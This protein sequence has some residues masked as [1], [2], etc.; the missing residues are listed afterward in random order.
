MVYRLGYRAGDDP[1]NE[2]FFSFVMSTLTFP[3]NCDSLKKI[4]NDLCVE[5]YVYTNAFS[6]S[7]LVADLFWIYKIWN[8]II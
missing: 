2:L 6:Q 8:V 4:R 7:E 1:Y 5:F 3:R